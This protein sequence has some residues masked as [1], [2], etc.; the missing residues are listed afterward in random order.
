[1]GPHSSDGKQVGQLPVDGLLPN[2]TVGLDEIDMHDESVLPHL[3]EFEYARKMLP[4]IEAASPQPSL[5]DQ[6][7]GDIEKWDLLNEVAQSQRPMKNRGG[8]QSCAE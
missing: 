4:R 6:I 3:H 2:F 5:D 1:M 7:P 8:P